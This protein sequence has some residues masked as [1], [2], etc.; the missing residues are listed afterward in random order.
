MSE[1]IVV[2][3]ETGEVKS[4]C[5]RGAMDETVDSYNTVRSRP[6]IN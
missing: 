1:G 2:S 3:L 5:R 4:R 6:N